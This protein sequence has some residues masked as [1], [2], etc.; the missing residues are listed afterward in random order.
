LLM[1]IQTSCQSCACHVCL[2]FLSCLLNVQIACQSFR[3]H[4]VRLSNV[5]LF[6]AVCCGFAR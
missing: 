4:A 3:C 2:S 5:M 1:D 6:A